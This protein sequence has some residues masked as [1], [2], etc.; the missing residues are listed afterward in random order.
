MNYFKTSKSTST[1]VCGLSA[2]LALS[3]IGCSDSESD[4]GLIGTGSGPTSPIYEL[5]HLPKRISP[6][7][8]KTLLKGDEITPIDS[9]DGSTKE[10][11]SSMRNQIFYSGKSEGWL[12]L[13]D[14]LGFVSLSRLGIENNATI[15]DLAFDDILNECAEQLLDCSIPA[16]TI[17]VTIT[18]NVVNRLIKLH[19]EW[20]ETAQVFVYSVSA[21]SSGN[22]TASITVEE[23]DSNPYNTSHEKI[24]SFFES[25]LNT[26]VVLGETRYSQLDGSPYDHVLQTTIKRG[27][28]Q[29][30]DFS[31]PFWRDEDFSASWH[32][33]GQVA[34]F[35]TGSPEWITHEYFYQNNVPSELV[36]SHLTSDDGNGYETGFFAKILGND[37]NQAGVLLEA[38]AQSLSYSSS[39]TGDNKV[40]REFSVFQGQ[41]D[42]NGGY[43]TV[44]ER[45]FDLS[46]EQN[47][48][49]YQGY[50]ESYDRIGEL[51]AGERCFP[52]DPFQENSICD[53]EMFVSYG[54]EGQEGSAITDSVHYFAPGEFDS[55][56]AVQDAIR[57]KVEG[58]PS[59]I[60]SIAVISAD[61]QSQLSESEFL[62]R[63]L[64]NVGDDGHIFCTATDEQLENTVV[65]ELVEGV[66][67]QV[68]PSAT[69]VQ[70]Q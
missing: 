18:Q 64:E 44:D 30:D 17:R 31:F 52:F 16:D 25:L 33:D 49:F 53:E 48:T 12:E 13:N 8:P 9:P 66:P 43:S 14:K 40:E 67:T 54:L 7:I 21:Q 24:S 23:G 22:M 37:P 28:D 55:L 36:V 57:W 26:E 39:S 46:E 5:E 10:S 27:A 38:V 69:L 56:A 61:S 6:D 1:L 32:E 41:W 70:I 68:I 34:T 3:L 47:L 50:R 60:K 42:N 19:T 62:C 29:V 4:G 63:G 65:V 15:V 20:A 45:T 2:L 59:G 35:S 51:L 11:H 58:V